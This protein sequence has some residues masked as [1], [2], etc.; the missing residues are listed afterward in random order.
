MTLRPTLALHEG[1][2]DVDFRVPLQDSR[3]V[4]T[5]RGIGAPRLGT[6]RRDR[7]SVPW[8][9]EKGQELCTW[10]PGEGTGAL[11]LGTRRRDRSSVIGDQEK[12]QELLPGDQEKEQELCDWGPGEGTGACDWGPGEGTGALRLGTRRRDRSSVIG[13]Q[14]K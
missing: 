14:E 9:Q 10:G 12:G 5:R 1:F 6:R 13:D 2:N 7:S 3:E 4:G 11:C 8:D